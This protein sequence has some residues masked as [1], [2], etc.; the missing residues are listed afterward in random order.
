MIKSE[1]YLPEWLKEHENCEG[2][3]FMNRCANDI[4]IA[5]DKFEKEVRKTNWPSRSRSV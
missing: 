4:I 1:C 3:P 5:I 2:C